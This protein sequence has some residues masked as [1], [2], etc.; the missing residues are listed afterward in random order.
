MSA[1]SDSPTLIVPFS[2]L[3]HNITYMYNPH[4]LD[5]TTHPLI[6]MYVSSCG[7]TDAPTMLQASIPSLGTVL[8]LIVWWYIG[9]CDMDGG[10]CYVSDVA[11]HVYVVCG[12]CVCV[13][14]WGYQC[15]TST[16]VTYTLTHSLK[17]PQLRGD[18]E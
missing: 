7:I 17:L 16:I 5:H 12:M 3:Q 13:F 1:C 8:K 9:A 6:Q 11:G 2:Q 10:D 14:V 15:T 18:C 4:N